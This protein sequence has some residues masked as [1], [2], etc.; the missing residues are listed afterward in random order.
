MMEG[1]LP[2]YDHY[3]VEA[4]WPDKPGLRLWAKFGLDEVVDAR[5]SA[6]RAKAN[7]AKEVR[8][9]MITRDLQETI[10]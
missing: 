6:D 1:D 9:Y 10:T 3:S 5:R 2:T 7:G 8:I 4:K